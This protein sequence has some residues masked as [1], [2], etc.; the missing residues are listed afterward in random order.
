MEPT[1][2]LAAMGGA[3]KN[4]VNSGLIQKVLGPTAE[5]L[6]E[7]FRDMAERRLTN[8]GRIFDVAERRLG[9]RINNKGS[10][11]PK[12]L[13]EVLESGSYAEEQLAAEYFGGILASSRSEVS[14]DDR[15]AALAGLVARQT[16]YQ[17][18]LHYLI[19]TALKLIYDGNTRYV[20]SDGTTIDDLYCYIPLES[21]CEAMD[22]APEE[23]GNSIL[24]HSLFG[25]ARDGLID[26]QFAA[27]MEPHHHWLGITHE[28]GLIVTPTAVGAEL[29]MWAH[30]LGHIWISEF[31]NPEVVFK[32]D[33]GIPIPP[34]MIKV[35]I[36]I[37]QKRAADRHAKEQRTIEHVENTPEHEKPAS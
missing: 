8:T 13:K 24:G 2:A 6:G 37:A 5:Y 21:Y 12:V 17:V 28:E 35:G 11:H 4:A 15:G 16:T 7:Y 29:Y 33:V 9:S 14:R 25:L 18:R 32:A 30:G 10:V 1:T 31:F 27:G 19:Y 34:Q 26:K 23:D 3:A 22:F 20:L 36:S